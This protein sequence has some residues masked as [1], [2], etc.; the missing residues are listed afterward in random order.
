MS[1]VPEADG[2]RMLNVDDV[3]EP[4]VVGVFLECLGSCRVPL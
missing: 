3:T 4:P 2:L 1:E